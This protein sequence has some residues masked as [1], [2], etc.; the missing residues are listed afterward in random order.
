M[1][2]TN[3]KLGI[4]PTQY[5]F[6]EKVEPIKYKYSV[7]TLVHS[8]RH[9]KHEYKVFIMVPIR[10]LT[11]ARL[12][13]IWFSWRIKQAF[14]FDFIFLVFYF[15]L[16]SVCVVCVSCLVLWI[17]EKRV[18]R[19]KK[20]KVKREKFII[21]CVRNKI[22]IR[23][24]IMNRTLNIWEHIFFYARRIWNHVWTAAHKMKSFFILWT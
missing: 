14:E 23:I 5:V 2:N 18:E 13:T 11:L 19:L 4:Y 12:F 21:C 17:K 6:V 10:S 22:W 20:G 8:H 9:S 7:H 1:H 15:I 24:I 16:N 3:I